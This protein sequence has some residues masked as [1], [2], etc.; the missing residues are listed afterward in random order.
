MLLFG[1]IFHEGCDVVKLLEMNG[2]PTGITQEEQDTFLKTPQRLVCTKKLESLFEEQKRK[3]KGIVMKLYLE[4][5][6]FF[7]D[8]FGY[9]YG[10]LLLREIAKYLCTIPGADVYRYTGVEFLLVLEGYT[11]AQMQ[12]VAEEIVKRFERIWSIQETDCICTMNMGVVFYPEFAQNA[13]ELM[14]NLDHAIAHSAQMGQNQLVE[15]DS[16]L[17]AALQRRKGIARAITAAVAEDKMNIGY[18]P[19]FCLPEDRFVRAEVCIQIL[20][21]EYGMIGEAEFLPV[22]EQSGQ[23]YALSSYAIHKVCELIRKLL[24]EG[25]EF[26]ALSMHISPIQLLQERFIQEL[27]QVLRKYHIPKG[28][29]ALAMDDNVTLTSFTSVNIALQQLSEMGIELMLSGFG[30]A[31]TGISSVLALPVDIVKLERLFIWQMETN[32]RSA[33]LIEGLCSIAD[34][35]GLKLIAEGVET[36]NQIEQLTSFGCNYHQGL[37]YSSMVEGSAL[38]ELFK[39]K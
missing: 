15:F 3:S 38:Q 33:S 24:D 35:L 4:N 14:E 25:V 8:T 10:G 36:K 34:S 39:S 7:N 20:S 16:Q 22:A 32:E 21:E 13:A 27:A 12:S 29:L 31:Y 26:E 9:H 11:Y 1:E 23:I 30:I 6:K 5:F 17:Y 2:T 19:V 28:K 37:Y 18:M